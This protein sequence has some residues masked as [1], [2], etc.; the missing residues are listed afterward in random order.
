[1]FAKASTDLESSVENR[2][3]NR[4]LDAS[5][6][7]LFFSLVAVL[8]A[9]TLTS[10][11][12]GTRTQSE[13]GIRGRSWCQPISRPPSA[14]SP[15]QLGDGPDERPSRDKQ[16]SEEVRS[17]HTPG[18]RHGASAT[19][20]AVSPTSTWI[21]TELNDQ[22]CSFCWKGFRETWVSLLTNPFSGT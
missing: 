5:I 16:F 8:Y 14:R 3:L 22:I 1:M 10:K 2:E 12:D 6:R 7:E 4:K 13:R 15:P 19:S 9:A 17:G 11:Q 21:T 18:V 20:T